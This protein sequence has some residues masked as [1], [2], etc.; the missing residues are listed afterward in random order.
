M[1]LNQNNGQNSMF[2]Q[3]HKNGCAVDGTSYP[4]LEEACVALDKAAQGGE[5]TAVDRLDQ[6]VRR[7][8]PE[9]CRTARNFGTKRKAPVLR[10]DNQ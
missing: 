5:I 3:I 1:P 7:Y 6:I 4:S 2:F 9:E 10:P 8:T